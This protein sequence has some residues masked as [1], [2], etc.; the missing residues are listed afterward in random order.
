MADLSSAEDRKEERRSHIPGLA[1]GEVIAHGATSVVR[2]A[3]CAATGRD[4]AIKILSLDRSGIDAHVRKEAKIHSRLLHKNIVVLRNAIYEREISFLVM[5]Y[6][7][8][9]ELFG[10]I[11]PGIGIFEKAFHLYLTQLH[12]A[13]T[14]IH[15]KGI[16]HRD[17][18]PENLLL[19]RKMNLL[20]SDF[21]C[22]TV[23][24]IGTARRILD[25]YNGSPNYMAPEIAAGKYDGEH[26]DVW[27]FGMVALVMLTGTVPWASP[28]M[29]DT[30]F[31]M[32]VHTK[33][34]DY[35]P[36]S[37]LCK[38]KKLFVESLLSVNPAKR[39]S[40]KEVGATAWMA[41]ENVLLG[42]DGMVKNPDVV[43]E[44]LMRPQA[45]SFSQPGECTSPP[46]WEYCSQ[47][48]FLTYDKVMIATRIYHSASIE[49]TLLLLQKV[50]DEFLIQHKVSGH[51]A[52][53]NTVD[54]QKNPL[55]GEIFCRHVEEQSCLVFKRT[56]GDCIEFKRMFNT[57]KERFVH[58]SRKLQRK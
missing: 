54:G 38:E 22:A 25:K 30:K 6:A 3:R 31:E 34:K 28:F 33:Y 20:L 1:F 13:L 48:S 29:G 11:E 18:K 49:N 8:G 46:G 9:G 43:R 10:Y 5:D 40:V 16:C 57:I 47:P 58:V 56:R 12:S 14:Y 55:S 2:K 7:H 37:S 52:S 42:K 4:F 32:Y 36:F 23:Y 26:V 50:L 19:D 39:P 44:A 41:R 27:S 35:P 45:P 17:I 51:A 15:S 53:F 24:R 21:G